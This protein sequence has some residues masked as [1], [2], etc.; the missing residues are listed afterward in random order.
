MSRT[1]LRAIA[2]LIVSIALIFVFYKN[3]PNKIEVKAS[4]SGEVREISAFIWE[5]FALISILVAISLLSGVIGV[6][7]IL[8]R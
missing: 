2:L 7:T 8:R 5:K 6:L 1:I 3:L 4:E